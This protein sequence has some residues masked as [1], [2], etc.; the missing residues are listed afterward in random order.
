MIIKGCLNSIQSLLYNSA[1]LVISLSLVYSPL[2]KRVGLPP[3]NAPFPG[4][5]VKSIEAAFLQSDALPGVKH[6]RGMQYQI[7]T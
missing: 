4:V 1:N 5:F 2:F 7:A 6:M 3:H